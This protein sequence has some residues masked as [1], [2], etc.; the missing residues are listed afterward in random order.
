M[1]DNSAFGKNMVSLRE[2]LGWNRAEF[3]RQ[4]SKA[5]YEFHL[6]TMRRLESGEQEPKLH[7]AIWIAEVLGVNVETLM[8]DSEQSPAK[9]EVIQKTA[10][11]KSAIFDAMKA[12]DNWSKT[13]EEL[14]TAIDTAL[15]A[16][17]P[18]KELFDAIDLTHRYPT[19]DF[20]VQAWD[21]GD[22][23]KPAFYKKGEKLINFD[24]I[25]ENNNR[26]KE[27][28]GEG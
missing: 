14:H 12:L 22:R 1:A 9:A 8:L 23:G 3:L 5:G 15:D 25:R 17:V 7:E 6:T 11:H 2:N 10:L 27:D 28:N 18:A 16:G 20:L 19:S 21:E 13:L 24:G 4:L 26:Q